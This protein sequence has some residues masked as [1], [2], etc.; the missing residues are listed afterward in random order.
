MNC[1]QIPFMFEVGC[2]GKGC[3]GGCKPVS[4]LAGNLSGGDA[5]F[6]KGEL[7]R[8]PLMFFRPGKS[9]AADRRKIGVVKQSEVTDNRLELLPNSRAS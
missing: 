9:C 5:T 7:R 1:W 8:A 6:G 2:K 3:L 4:I